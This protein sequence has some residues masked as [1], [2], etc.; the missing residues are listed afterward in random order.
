MNPHYQVLGLNSNATEEDIKKAYR[1]LSKKYH[2]DLNPGNPNAEDMFK[3]VSEA[4]THLT[5]T[6]KH[7]YNNNDFFSS[8]QRRR[9]PKA[10]TILYNLEITLEEA[11]FGTEKQLEIVRDVVCDSCNGD[12]GIDK[13]SCNQCNGQGILKGDNTFYMCNNCMGKGFLFMKK[14][15]TCHM[16]GYKTEK[17]II[18][19]NINPSILNN[20]NITKFGVGSEVKDGLNG[21]VLIST[22][23]KKHKHFTLE[24]YDLKMKKPLSVLDVIL[25][26]EFNVKTIDG[27]VKIKIP[28]FSDINNYFRVK[29][30]GM[31]KENN[32]RGDLYV[33]IE[34]KYPKKIN[35]QE[36]ALINALKNSPNFKLD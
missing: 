32:K 7:T 8:F 15:G 20:M 23:I 14:C 10:R 22:S 17:K 19:I 29:N 11:F 25:G 13:V 18:T 35:P 9:K 30:K 26:G 1:K 33:K 28:Q 36:M 3:K 34:P 5:D 4:Y 31:R 24:G 2:P 21:D 27:E 6:K 12:G 16:S